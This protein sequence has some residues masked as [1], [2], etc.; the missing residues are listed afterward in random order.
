VPG[1]PKR[2]WS[3]ELVHDRFLTPSLLAMALGNALQA[4]GAERQ[5]VTWRAES[6][7]SIVGH[8]ELRV[9]DFGVS[10]G[11]TPDPREFSGSQLV[12]AV[13]ALVNNPWQPAFVQSVQTT[14]K[15]AYA[16]EIVRLRG[17][18][19]LEAELDAGQPARL[20]LTLVPYAG[21]AFTR[22]ISVPLPRHLAGSTVKL[23]IRPG[24]SVE[25]EKAAPESLDDLIRNLQDPIY[26]PKSIVVS[27]ASGAGV[28]FKGRVVTQLPA[29]ALD[30]IR[31]SSASFSPEAFR[32]EQR[33]VIELPQ[34]MV[35]SDTVSVKIRPAL[36]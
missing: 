22:T 19:A 15:I 35:G 34:F 8:A 14:V 5:D 18:R 3:F 2:D 16:R 1:A 32:S 28:G 4:T 23:S 24:H 29:S 9:E 30:S 25:R 20:S 27:Y 13:G 31:Q 6:K 17:A 10:I 11:G 26:P 36:R 7:V 33:E 12:S 21:P